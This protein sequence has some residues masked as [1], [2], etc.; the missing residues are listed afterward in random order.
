MKQGTKIVAWF[1]EI[2]KEDIAIAGGK[3][4]NLGEMTKARIPIPPGFVITSEA[5]FEFLKT[6]LIHEVSKHLESLDVND[7]R[8]LQEVANTIKD[9]ISR[10]PMPSYMVDEIKKAYRKLGD[11]LVAVRSSAT[12]EERSKARRFGCSLCMTTGST[13]FPTLFT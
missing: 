6:G 9:K 13:F 1:A 5:Y 7:S 12:A 10:A 8:K 4:A 11:G 2:T 3:G